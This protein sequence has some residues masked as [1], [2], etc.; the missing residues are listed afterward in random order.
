[1]QA[2]SP[3]FGPLVEAAWLADH[4]AEVVVCDVRWYLDG[5]S[6]RAAFEAGHIPGARFVDV[7]VDLAGPPGGTAGRHPLPDPGAFAQSMSALGIGDGTEVVAYDDTGGGTA[8]RLVWMLRVL[9]EPA[10]LLDGGL[11]GWAGPLANGEAPAP[12]HAEFTERT[13]PEAAI[14]S[15]DDLATDLARG[16]TVAIDA[17]AGERYRGEVEPVDPRAGHVPG[18]QSVPWATLLD[19]E[20]GRF[21][22]R[23][24]MRDRFAEAG[25]REDTAVVAYCGSGVTACIDIVAMEIAGLRPARLFASSWSGWCADPERPAATGA[26]PGEAA[27]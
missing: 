8:A 1:V 10:A 24:A 19:P 16:S 27:R 14:I 18:A 2:S 26:E 21:R 22:S 17:R 9:G 4:L 7:D 3:T 13:W 5:R 15:A 12:P 20:T 6:G 23:E 11:A 25:V